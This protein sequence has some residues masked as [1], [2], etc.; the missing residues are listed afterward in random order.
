M[1]TSLQ[2]D[3]VARDGERLVLGDSKGIAGI[4][5]GLKQIEEGLTSDFVKD[6]AKKRQMLMFE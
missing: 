6:Y 1:K 5:K 4:D 3:Y 2:L